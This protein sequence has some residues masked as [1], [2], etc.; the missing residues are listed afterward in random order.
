MSVTGSPPTE[1]TVPSQSIFDILPSWLVSVAVHVGLFFLCAMALRSCHGEL[2]SVG[3]EEG[4]RMVGVYVKSPDNAPIPNPQQ[5]TAEQT[6]TTS[7][8]VA[9]FPE[10]SELDEPPIKPSLPNIPVLG[11]GNAPQ[12]LN[13]SNVQNLASVSASAA[14]AAAIAGGGGA[15]SMFGIRDSGRRFVYVIDC[16]GSMYGEPMRVAKSELLA[17]L[18]SLD[19]KQRFGVI[20]YNAATSVMRFRGDTQNQL[21]EATDSN[22]SAA[23]S[24]IATQQPKAGTKHMLALQA[25]LRLNPDVVYFLTDAKRPILSARE[26]AQVID[27]NQ[28]RARIHCIEFGSGPELRDDNF[29]K[30]LARQNGGRYQ[31][32][33]VDRFRPAP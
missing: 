28:G 2:G 17:S 27:I 24:F 29:L 7:S 33:D 21:Y 9:P 10:T 30:K 8:D 11:S 20:F 5:S 31:Y 23:R 14:N 6:N 32:R 4:D 1:P 13:P 15:T 19:R 3:T 25:A 26:L 16:S 22:R 18:Q 12:S